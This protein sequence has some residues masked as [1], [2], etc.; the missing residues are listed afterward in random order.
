MKKV[1]KY[2]EL[3]KK[4]KKGFLPSCLLITFLSSEETR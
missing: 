2:I 4:K 3:K 1:K